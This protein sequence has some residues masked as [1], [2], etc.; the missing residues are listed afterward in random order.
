MDV[1]IYPCQYSTH[2]NRSRVTLIYVSKLTIIGSDNGLTPGRGQAMIM[3]YFHLRKC[4]IS[5]LRNVDHFRRGLLVLVRVSKRG[6]W[7][8]DIG[9]L[10]WLLLWHYCDVIMGAN[11]SQITSLTINENIKTPRHWGLREWRT[12]ITVS[13]LTSV[14]MNISKI[15]WHEG[16]LRQSLCRGLS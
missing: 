11:E 15:T 13:L 1:F 4:W 7:W 5:R 9:I 16:R 14:L 3:I 12:Y 6:P 8:I 2:W 10:E